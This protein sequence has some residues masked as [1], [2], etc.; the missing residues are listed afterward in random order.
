VT[1]FVDPG[2][3]GAVW[4]DAYGVAASYA[5]I[6]QRTLLVWL[7]D[8]EPPI[9]VESRLDDEYCSLKSLLGG[10]V[11]QVGYECVYPGVLPSLDVMWFGRRIDSIDSAFSCFLDCPC[12]LLEQLDHLA[13]SYEHV[14]VAGYDSRYRYLSAAILKSSDALVLAVDVDRYSLAE[15]GQLLVTAGVAGRQGGERVPVEAVYLRGYDRRLNSC[16]RVHEEL[17]MIFAARLLYTSL[18]F[19]VGDGFGVEKWFVSGDLGLYRALAG[20]LDVRLRFPKRSSC[21][22]PLSG[23]LRQ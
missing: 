9:G 8:A 10:A 7:V 20:E 16:I 23:Q 17:K 15:V 19:G 1:A 12:S 5:R 14:I 11:A 22:A 4:G 3:N 2:T 18:P 6:G 21:C 13:D